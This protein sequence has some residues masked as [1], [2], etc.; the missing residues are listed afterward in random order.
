MPGRYDVT[1]HGALRLTRAEV[2]AVGR[3]VD[4]LVED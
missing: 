4:D 3:D 1:S 2:D